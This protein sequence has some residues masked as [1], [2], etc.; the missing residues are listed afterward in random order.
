M[1]EAVCDGLAA[2][3]L[4]K[5]YFTEVLG[6]ENRD[7]EIKKVS[8]EN[9]KFIIECCVHGGIYDSHYRAIVDENCR[10]I[11]VHKV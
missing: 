9:G 3:L 10:L 11:K 6:V 4:V 5:K 8:Y 2:S 7:F 1:D